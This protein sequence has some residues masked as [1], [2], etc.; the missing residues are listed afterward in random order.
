[1]LVQTS[2]R[3]INQLV[4]DLLTVLVTEPHGRKLSRDEVLDEHVG[5]LDHLINDLET[6]RFLEVDAYGAFVTVC[7][8][9]VGR[10]WREVGCG[11]WS[12]WG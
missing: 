1:M 9:K 4:I 11:F 8:K 10:L 3:S 12:F 6:C 7:G 5:V 2:N